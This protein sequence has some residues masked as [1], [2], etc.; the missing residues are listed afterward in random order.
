MITQWSW[1]FWSSSMSGFVLKCIFL[2][3]SFCVNLPYLFHRVKSKIQFCFLKGEI[4]QLWKERD[5]TFQKLCFVLCSREYTHV[6]M[7]HERILTTCTHAS[8][9]NSYNQLIMSL[10]HWISGWVPKPWGDS[11]CHQK[12]CSK[13]GL[14]L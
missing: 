7:L 6:L 4:L 8:W 12:F 9:E 2:S 10:C 14:F 13:T 3:L 5:F 11:R 1:C